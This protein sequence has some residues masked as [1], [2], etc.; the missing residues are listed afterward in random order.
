MVLQIGILYSNDIPP[1][2]GGFLCELPLL[3]PYFARDGSIRLVVDN[4]SAVHPS[5]H[6]L[7][8]LKHRQ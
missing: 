8:R 3:S 5:H 6:V 2:F 4:Y 7:N 1:N